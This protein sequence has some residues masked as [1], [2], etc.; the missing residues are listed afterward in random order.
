MKGIYPISGATVSDA[1]HPEFKHAFVV[2]HK[3]KN[4]LILAAETA[5]LKA[6][7]EKAIKDSSKL[8]PGEY[9][10]KENPNKYMKT[11]GIPNGPSD[12]PTHSGH[13]AGR[14]LSSVGDEELESVFKFKALQNDPQHGGKQ[15][16]FDK[17]HDA[18]NMLVQLKKYR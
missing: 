1:T 9:H 8:E 7:W 12:Y 13:R 6:L 4:P 3:D 14:T 11:L 17:I 10:G 18:Y 5:N 2:Q 15:E 16:D